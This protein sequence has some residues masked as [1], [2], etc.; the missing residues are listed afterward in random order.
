[1]ENIPDKITLTFNI[2]GIPLFKSSATN[3][4]PI[5]CYLIKDCVFPIA[6]FVG[7]IKPDPLPDFLSK[8]CVELTLLLENG[9]IIGGKVHPVS[10]RAFLCDAPARAHIKNTQNHTGYFACEEY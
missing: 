9:I 1:M 4:W 3:L 10:C 8:F 7:K 6:L 5:L 2:D